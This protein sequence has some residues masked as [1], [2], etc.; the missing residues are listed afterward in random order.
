MRPDYTITLSAPAKVN[1]HLNVL[2]KRPDGFHNIETIFERIDLCDQLH[3]K[4]L[5]KKEIRIRCDHPHVPCGPKNLVYKVA[6]Q[7]QKD[8]QPKTGVEITIRKK[9]PVAAGLAGGSSNAAT[10]LL[11]LN[12]LW[13]LKLKKSQMVEYAS[14]VG[15]DVA[16]FLY[17]TSFGLGTDRGQV[18]TPLKIRQK[19]WHILVVPKVKVYAKDVYQNFRLKKCSSGAKKAKNQGLPADLL[20]EENMLTNISD[21]ANILIHYL[22]NKSFLDII[23]H[24]SNDLEK[25]VIDLCPKL[26]ALQERLKL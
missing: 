20:V 9:I 13:Q 26:S 1:L 21:N 22:R 15:S 14:Q 8:F 11:G 5:P 25:T 6:S 2:G 4:L 12:Y 23:S 19:L 16:F 24:I 10:T 17:D 7:L 18:I 3:F